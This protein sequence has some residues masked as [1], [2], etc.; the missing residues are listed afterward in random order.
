MTG[1]SLT[2]MS[3]T[4]VCPY[5]V[6]SVWYATIREH[7]LKAYLARYGGYMPK[8]ELMAGWAELSVTICIGHFVMQ[9]QQEFSPAGL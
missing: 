7:A 8:G 3:Q 4:G 9:W 2:G 5:S 6:C 1:V